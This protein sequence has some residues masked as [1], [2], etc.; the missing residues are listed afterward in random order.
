MVGENFYSSSWKACRRTCALEDPTHTLGGHYQLSSL[1]LQDHFD[2]IFLQ[3]PA[4]ENLT[5]S[6]NRF[7]H[8]KM[9]A[10]THEFELPLCV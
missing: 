4:S 5:H 2:H 1:V 9:K 8:Y 6:V 3:V 7:G 10:D